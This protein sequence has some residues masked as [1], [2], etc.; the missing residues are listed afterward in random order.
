M[1]KLTIKKFGPIEECVVDVANFMVL[2]GPQASGKSTI[3][4]SVFFFL[5]IREEMIQFILDNVEKQEIYIKK[6]FAK[7]IRGRFVEF[8][9]PIPPNEELYIRRLM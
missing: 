2:I 6:D 7:H 1:H 3:S 4:K 8:F 5:N 9:G